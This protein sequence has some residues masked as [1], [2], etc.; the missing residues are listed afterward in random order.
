MHFQKL[1]SF[2]WSVAERIFAAMEGKLSR[3]V[4]LGFSGQREQSRYQASHR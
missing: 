3:M 1:A 2:L 4:Y